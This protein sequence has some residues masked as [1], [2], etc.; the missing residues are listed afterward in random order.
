V[1]PAARSPSSPPREAF[2]GDDDDAEE[3]DGWDTVPR[4]GPA[5]AATS[6]RS[7]SKMQRLVRKLGA[8]LSPRKRTKVLVQEMDSPGPPPLP[9]KIIGRKMKP[10]DVR[11][12][13]KH[14]KKALSD[15]HLEKIFKKGGYIY[16]NQ[17]KC[18]V[19]VNFLSGRR[20]ERH[21]ELTIVTA[22]RFR[23]KR[24]AW[25]LLLH[26]LPLLFEK[27]VGN[28]ARPVSRVSGF[29]SSLYFAK[30]LD[31]IGQDPKYKVGH[32]GQYA[33]FNIYTTSVLET[34]AEVAHVGK[35]VRQSKGAVAVSVD[36]VGS[37]S[38]SDSS[39]E[40]EELGIS[41]GCDCGC[42]RDCGCSG[43]GS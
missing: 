27:R 17:N 19:F 25:Q 38:T 22:V 13:K 29:V 41:S 16:T 36:D 6:P 11:N 14:T 23:K 20:G 10:T 7:P 4:P 28:P 34:E 3:H 18:A 30:L 31:R 1:S 5:A 12:W 8:V 33:P 39:C 40:E 35:K 2:V 42:D 26:V 37:E 21:A 15:G 43:G 32:M 24:L 9:K